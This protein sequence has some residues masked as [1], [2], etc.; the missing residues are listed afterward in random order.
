MACH[1]DEP[2]SGGKPLSH[3]VAEARKV[4]FMSFWNSDKDERRRI[5]FTRLVE[6]GEPAVPA[7]VDL[8]ESEGQPVS[9]DALNALAALGPRA[10]SAVPHLAT[11]L[12][13]GTRA[14]RIDAM[15]ILGKIGPAASSSIPAITKALNDPDPRVARVA[16][17]ALANF[18]VAESAASNRTR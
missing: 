6:I 8:L 17:M 10:R 18:R 16:G 14:Q 12:S 2:I 9:G 13:Q 3:W 11:L 1:R 7:L 4:S 15:L 5:A